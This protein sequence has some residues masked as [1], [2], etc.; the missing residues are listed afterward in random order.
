MTH[1]RNPAHAVAFGFS[2]QKG[3]YAVLQTYDTYPLA[4]K[5]YTEASIARA[6]RLRMTRIKQS[7]NARTIAQRLLEQGLEKCPLVSVNRRL[8]VR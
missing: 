3:L 6:I 4:T 7:V 2:P 8:I 5:D 1:V